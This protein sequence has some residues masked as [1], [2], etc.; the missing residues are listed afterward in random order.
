MTSRLLRFAASSLLAAG[1]ATVAIASPT[2]LAPRPALAQDED[3]RTNIRVYEEASPAVVAIVAGEGTGS[4]SIVTSDG[5]VLTNSH[6]VANAGRT[7]TVRLADGREYVADVIGFDPSGQDLAA[8][9]IRNARNLPTIDIAPIDSVQVGQRAFAIG[10]PFGFENTFTV[11]IVSRIDPNDGTIQTDAAINPGNS[12]GPLLN[13]DAEM[14]G[15]NTAIFTLGREGGNIG[16][17]FAIPVRD[18]RSFLA[19]V[20][21]NRV[22]TT[23]QIGSRLPGSQL[24]QTLALNDPP[25]DGELGNGD[26]V[27]PVDNSYFDAYMFEGNAGQTVTLAMSS[28]EFDPYLILL[29]PNGSDVAQD[30]N[31]GGNRNARIHVRLPE[32][33]RYILL[34]NSNQ[35]GESGRYRL[36]LNS[37]D[38]NVAPSPPTGNLLLQERGQL[39]AGDLVLP[40]DGSLYDVYRFEGR[41]GQ[42]VTVTLESPDFDTYLLLLSEA[43]RPIAQNDDIGPGNT[44]SA[45]QVRLPYTGTYFVWVNAYDNTGRGRYELT[46]R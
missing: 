25:V 1:L 21:D 38:R 45:L 26:N 19:S 23:P 42:T 39:Q 30:N 36:S 15:V 35:G 6:V 34:A 24:P 17:G 29:G 12:G 33:G 37:G 2:P 22:A 13:S 20:G 31:G 10:S 41:E 5:L 3:E 43:V 46:V 4:G 18:V 16:I 27:L 9:Q 28:L 14:V 32:T 40:E 11:G 44:N 7:V 8:L